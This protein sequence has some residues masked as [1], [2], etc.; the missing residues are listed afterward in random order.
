MHKV[1][2]Q[3]VKCDH[4]LI[5]LVS[6]LDLY[7]IITY[8]LFLWC[9]YFRYQNDFDKFTLSNFLDIVKIIDRID[10]SSQ[11]VDAMNKL[12]DR[13]NNKLNELQIKYANEASK[14]SILGEQLKVLGL[15]EN[16][17]YLFIQGHTIKDNVVLMF[18][19]PIALALKKIMRDEIK[20]KAI[21]RTEFVVEI[22]HYNNNLIDIETVL[23]VNMD[24][25]SC[26]LYQKI[27][28]DL[29][30]YLRGIL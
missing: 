20:N 2:V 11:G 19:K 4:K 26:S 5:D 7:S 9:I 23:N 3:S 28:N 10:V 18:L 29:R 1:C 24:F 16:T 13:V 8:P 30:N 25:K 14:V 21:H 15:N 22:N 6:L 12:R 17:T 27:E